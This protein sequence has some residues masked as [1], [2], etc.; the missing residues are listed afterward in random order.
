[1]IL[2][3]PGLHALPAARRARRLAL[4]AH[5]AHR[6]AGAR[7]RR[8]R[9]A[10]VRLEPSRAVAAARP[11]AR[12]A[13]TRSATFWFDVTKSDWRDTMVLNVPPSLSGDHAAMYGSTSGSSSASSGRLLAAAGAVQL[14]RA[15]TAARRCSCSRLYGVNVVFAL[16]YNVGDAHVFYLPSHLMVALLAAP[17]LVLAGRIAGSARATWPPLLAL[18]SGRRRARIGDYP[19]ARSQ[20]RPAADRG[21]RGAHRGPRRSARHP[22]HRS[23]TGRSR[24][25]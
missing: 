22:A 19:G 3:A 12:P 4:A 16:S 7:V 18:D 6:R 2:L 14:I 15:R 24:T 23:R 25:A 10:A 11:A 17:G 5:A 9:R 8:R 20:R 1:M 21:A 13:S